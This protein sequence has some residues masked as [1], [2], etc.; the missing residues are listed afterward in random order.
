MKA[1]IL[2]A[3][4][5]SRMKE[6]T[7]SIPKC[8]MML[9]GITL[10]ERCIESLKKA[11]FKLSDIGIVTGYKCEKIKVKDVYYFHNANWQTTNMFVSLTMAEKWLLQEPCIVC[12]SDIVFSPN[13]VK[14]L[15]ESKSEFAI[16]YYTEF[17]D[18]WQKRFENPFNDLESFKLHEGKLL[19]IGKKA[20]SRDSI[21]GQ[22][23]GLLRFEPS[24]WR[25]V[26]Q[27]IKLPIQKSIS[28]LDMTTL[29]QHLITIGHDVEAIE[30][31]ELWL[32]CDNLDDIRLYEYEANA[33]VGAA[34]S[35]PRFNP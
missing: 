16:T 21:H 8:L 13:A 33:A 1:I 26:K 2:A 22:Y 19:E 29:L 14:K 7:T 11:G 25:K 23:M 35:R 28:K 3:G 10:L 32:E 18:L 34:F 5:G 15:M 6:G 9:G 24:G 31:E 20:T 17:W 4:R 30:E 12:Y 27:A